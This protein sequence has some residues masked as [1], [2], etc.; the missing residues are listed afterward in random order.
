MTKTVMAG[1]VAFATLAVALVLGSQAVG[2][3][4]KATPFVTTVLGFIGLSVT[5]LMAHAKTEKTEK[6]VGELNADL[7]NGTFERLLRE[8]ILKVARDGNTRLN[9][10]TDTTADREDM[11]PPEGGQSE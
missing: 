3:D 2:V 7:R 10:N 9:I 4:E 6:T 8:A 11:Q 5:Q 1:A